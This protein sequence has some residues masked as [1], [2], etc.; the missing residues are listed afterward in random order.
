[1]NVTSSSQ[2]MSLGRCWRH[3]GLSKRQFSF[4]SFKFKTLS[5]SQGQPVT[6]ATAINL[7]Q[8]RLSG[9]FLMSDSMILS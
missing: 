3:P 8:N 5:L 1:M 4:E 9:E 6:A 2:V 7:N